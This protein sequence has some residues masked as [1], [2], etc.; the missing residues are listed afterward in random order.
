M[1]IF[2]K[3]SFWKTRLSTAEW[4]DFAIVFDYLQKYRVKIICQHNAEVLIRM[5]DIVI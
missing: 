4:T 3:S 5:K 1:N 2:D